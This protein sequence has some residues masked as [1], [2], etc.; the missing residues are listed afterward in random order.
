MSERQVA[1]LV[2]AVDNHGNP[3]VECPVCRTRRQV[4]I[5]EHPEG[6]AAYLSSHLHNGERCAGSQRA[7]PGFFL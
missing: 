7:V 1:S 3:M 4:Y 5:V 2:V 6:E